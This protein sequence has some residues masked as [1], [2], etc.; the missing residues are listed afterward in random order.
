MEREQIISLK[1]FIKTTLL[2]INAAVVESLKEGLPLAFRSSDGLPICKTVEFDIAVQITQNETTGK[3]RDTGLGISVV[4][5]NFSKDHEN[6]SEQLRTNRIKF[7]VDVFLGADI[8][9]INDE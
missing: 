1:D 8:T 4:N 3:K 5:L 7:S 2:A 9:K 6:S